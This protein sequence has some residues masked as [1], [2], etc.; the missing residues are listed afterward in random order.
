MLNDDCWDERWIGFYEHDS[1]T[2][3]AGLVLQARQHFG[4]KAQQLHVDTT[5]FSVRG[6]YQPE[7]ETGNG[8][9]N[10]FINIFSARL[11]LRIVNCIFSLRKLRN[12]ESRDAL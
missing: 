10:L 2:L 7:E 11:V 4:I 1:T 6:E 5:P 8:D 3:F 9:C 12:G